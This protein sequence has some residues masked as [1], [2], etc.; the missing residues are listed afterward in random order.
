MA[1]ALIDGWLNSRASGSS[2]SAPAKLTSKVV[3]ALPPLGVRTVRNGLGNWESGGGW[4]ASW[5]VAPASVMNEANS[6]KPS[7]RVLRIGYLLVDENAG[8][9]GRGRAR[10]GPSNNGVRAAV[11]EGDN[12]RRTGWMMDPL[13]VRWRV[14]AAAPPTQQRMVIRRARV[15]KED[16]EKFSAHGIA[17]IQSLSERYSMLFV[18]PFSERPASC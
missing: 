14:G 6:S 2:K 18:V 9:D 17:S 5:L 8:S 11:V 1:S 16:C 4:P 3:P 15:V 10:L 7:W 13:C 12:E